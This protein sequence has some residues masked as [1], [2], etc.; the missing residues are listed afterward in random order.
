MPFVGSFPVTTP[1]LIKACNPMIIVSP[2]AN[3]APNL[4]SVR[5]AIEIP[6]QTNIIKINMTVAAPIKPNSSPK[7]EKIKSVC[8]CGK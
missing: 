7:I 5:L 4:F 3:S 1:I 2:V 6:L 8:G